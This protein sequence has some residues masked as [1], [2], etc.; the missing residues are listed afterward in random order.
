MIN[1]FPILPAIAIVL[2]ATTAPAFAD[3]VKVVAAENFY[4]DLA[5]QI[6]SSFAV[7]SDAR[8]ASAASA[9]GRNSRLR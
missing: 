1:K 4:G 5:N 7:H 6:G 3:P 2:A 9:Q 8:N